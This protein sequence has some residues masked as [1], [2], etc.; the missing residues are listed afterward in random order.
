MDELID[1]LY[2]EFGGRE[3]PR[4]ER[5]KE[6]LAEYSSMCDQVQGVFG[7]GFV[8]RLMELKAELDHADELSDF[9]Q[10]LCLGARLAL[11]LF[12]PA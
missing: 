4:P 10:G 7:L 11:E 3:D 6:A 5:E 2:A 12:R 8:D 1:Q 9:R